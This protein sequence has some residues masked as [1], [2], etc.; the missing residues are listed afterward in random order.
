LMILSYTT[1]FCWH[2]CSTCRSEVL[3]SIA[4]WLLFDVV[5]M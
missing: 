1:P 2:W 4:N 3:C 5:L